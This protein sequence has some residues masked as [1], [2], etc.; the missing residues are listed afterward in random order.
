MTKAFA[1]LASVALLAGTN[2][3]GQS[4]RDS[5]EG[6]W[7]TVEV[8]VTGPGARTITIPEPRPNLAIVTAKY[9]SRMEIH[10]DAARPMLADA[11]KA[12][13]DELRAV[14]G[15]FVGEAGTYEMTGDRRVTMR[16]IVAKNPAA[17]SRGAFVTY[18]YKLEGDTLWVT[19]EKNQDGPI[20]NPA[21]IKLVRIE[22]ASAR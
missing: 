7:Q 2:V 5:L 21:T 22:H 14:W 12:T 6:V 13:A 9:Y 19:F 1:V 18:T 8:T 11:T 17:M 16:P 15:P 20:S 10:A 4:K 3:A